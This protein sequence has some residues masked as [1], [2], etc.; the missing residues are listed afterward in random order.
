M[1]SDG[2]RAIRSRLNRAAVVVRERFGLASTDAAL[3]AEEGNDG[4]LLRS[5]IHHFD[6]GDSRPRVNERRRTI[7]DEGER[8]S[9]APPWVANEQKVI[10]RV[11]QIIDLGNDGIFVINVK[12]YSDRQVNHLLSQF[13]VR[14]I[15]RA[16]SGTPTQARTQ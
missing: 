10:F 6:V 5:F 11:R 8:F 1:S 16:E 12:N 15:Q 7:R 13:A 3:F 9:V 4:V 2:P 14:C